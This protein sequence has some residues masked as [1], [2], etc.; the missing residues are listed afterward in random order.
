MKRLEDM[1]A[2]DIVYYK[3]YEGI[4]EHGRATIEEIY[5][6]NTT[7]DHEARCMVDLPGKP[8]LNATAIKPHHELHTNG[9]IAISNADIDQTRQAEADELAPKVGGNPDVIMDI[10]D[11]EEV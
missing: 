7:W 9:R 6:V 4:K 1:K 5:N 3:S 2:G 8:V 10:L 11:N